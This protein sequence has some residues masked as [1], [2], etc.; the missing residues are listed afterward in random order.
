MN[1]NDTYGSYAKTLET[2]ARIYDVARHMR[3]S[4]AARRGWVTRRAN[5]ARKA[6]S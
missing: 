5:L 6:G 1:V 2:I 4:D 3:R